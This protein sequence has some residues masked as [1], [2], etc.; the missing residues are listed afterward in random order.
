MLVSAF[1]GLA[2]GTSGYHGRVEVFTMGEW[3]T[4]CDDAWD[5][6]DANTACRQLGFPFGASESIQ[7]FGGG[8][9]RIWLD[10]LA[11]GP[12][13]QNLLTCPGNPI[14]THNCAHFEDAGARCIPVRKY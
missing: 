12:T 3:G 6:N 8:T 9:G 4:V 5:I 11:C 1:L 2:G 10:N 14:G 13:D 7:R